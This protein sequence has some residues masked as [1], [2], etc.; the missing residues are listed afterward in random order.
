MRSVISCIYIQHIELHHARQQPSQAAGQTT[1]T[2]LAGA[3]SVRR[4]TTI[5]ARRLRLGAAIA[6]GPLWME[7]YGAIR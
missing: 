7:H 3:I 5:Q 4:F 1:V 6:A 2:P